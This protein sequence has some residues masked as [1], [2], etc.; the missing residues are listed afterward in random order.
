MPYDG[1]AYRLDRTPGRQSAAPNLGEHTDE[2]LS[3]LLGLSAARSAR[4]A[5]TTSSTDRR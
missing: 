1:L 2:V 5:R 3:S 4:C